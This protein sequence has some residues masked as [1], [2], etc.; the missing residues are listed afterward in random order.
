MIWFLCLYTYLYH[1]P[2][3][4][5]IPPLGTSLLG[6]M[7]K[8]EVDYTFCILVILYIPV[9]FWSDRKFEIHP[10]R[11]AAIDQCG[12]LDDYFSDKDE[13]LGIYSL[14]S[15]NSTKMDLDITTVVIS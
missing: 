4:Y 2:Q 13:F 10:Q 14:S 3:A 6:G 15:D 9:F 1:V 5:G 8:N 12:K 7:N 11:I